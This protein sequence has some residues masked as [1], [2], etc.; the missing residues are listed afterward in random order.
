MSGWAVAAAIVSAVVAVGGTAYSA[1][2]SADAADEQA[3]LQEEQAKQE[4]AAAQTE[5]EAI[6]EKGQRVASSQNAALAASGVKLDDT[7]SSAAL[8]TETKNLAEKDALAAITTGNNRA[9]LLNAQANISRDKGTASLISGGLSAGS[10]LLGSAN[11]FQ[12][13]TQ[14]SKLASQINLDTSKLYTS[15]TKYSLLGD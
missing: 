3:K 2:A 10:T 15:K 6:R 1:V 8:L 5:A 4:Q 12:K 7:G 13:S 14:G 11:S 9:T